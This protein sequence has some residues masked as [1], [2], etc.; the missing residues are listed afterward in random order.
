LLYLTLTH[1]HT[2]RLIPLNRSKTYAKDCLDVYLRLHGWPVTYASSYSDQA[3]DGWA[4][5]IRAWKAGQEP[6]NAKRIS[7]HKPPP[8]Q[9]RD[10]YVY[11]DNDRQAHAPQDALRLA[12]QLGLHDPQAL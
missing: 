3:L 11:F 6:H 1:G 9:T 2:K 10:L 7:N 8:R 5:R 12:A 4:A